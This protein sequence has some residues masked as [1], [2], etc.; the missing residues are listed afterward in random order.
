MS[1]QRPLSAA[2]L[3]WRI[4]WRDGRAGELHV[5]LLAVVLAV[6]AMTAVA[7]L[8]DRLQAALRRDAGA[9]LGGDLVVRSDQPLPLAIQALTSQFHLQTSQSLSF[10][11]MVRAPDELGGGTKLVT[12]KAVDTAYPLRGRLQLAVVPSDT[13]GVVWSGPPTPGSVWVEP[14]LLLDLG[15]QVGQPL[16]LG[17]V[18]LPIS[19]V[20]LQ[21]PDRGAGFTSFLPRVLVH[22][23][24][25]AATQLVQPA[26]RIDYRLAVVADA[27]TLAGYRAALATQLAASAVRGVSTETLD[28]G[29]PEMQQTLQRAEQFLN[30]VALL[31]TVL[32]AVAVALAARWYAVRHLD[33]CAVLRVL[34][35][36]QHTMARAYG[37]ALLCLALLASSFGVAVGYA[38][39]GLLLSWLAAWLPAQ[40]PGASA[41]PIG[42]G[43]A[44]GSILVLTFAWPPVL[45]LAQVPPLRVMR[46]ELGQP[47]A[48]SALVFC[49]GLAGLSALLLLSSRDWRLGLLTVC[50]FGLALLVFAGL[51][52]CVLWLVRYGLAQLAWPIWV[53]MVLRQ[54]SARPMAAVLQIST[55]A[56]GLLAL[57]LLGLLRIE[58]LDSWR[59]V[60][61]VDAPN[62]FVINI[63]PEQSQALQAVLHT[64]GVHQYDWYPMVRGRLLQV[65]G[66][67]VNGADYTQER[68]QRL[69]EREFNLSFSAERPAHNPLTAGRWQAG[70]EDQISVEQG[71]AAAL[72]LQ[73][74]DELVFDIAGRKRVATIASLRQVNWGSMRVNFFA[75]YPV[76]ELSDW[77]VTYITAFHVPANSRIDAEL[78]RLFPNVTVLDLSRT[79]AQV[80]Q[81]LEQVVQ[82][83]QALFV[84]T[85]CAGLLVLFM[86]L[87]AGRREREQEWAVLRVLG[88]QAVQLRRM[89]WLEL[90]GVGAIAGGLAP[91]VAE[92]MA[93]LLAQQVLALPWQFHGWVLFAGAGLGAALACAAGWWGLRGL[94]RT[95]VLATLRRFQA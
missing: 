88:A 68:A 55:L 37:L 93:A 12:L 6:A 84:F 47:K 15:L 32:S 76:A 89:Q 54:W 18:C 16:C 8:A 21:E 42:L 4:V 35:L 51:A 45:Q 49:L 36:S 75:I 40:L 83:V 81:V 70:A 31:A 44:V 20:V 13:D 33:D 22:E 57:L 95:P 82:A 34:G 69:V 66:H 25:L 78:V 92:I 77:P 19:H 65:N 58:L 43:L 94:L 86:T 73:L 56:L 64:Q 26:S 5:L 59:S 2:S 38:V 3:A 11:T 30:L 24:D 48:M 10:S 1:K 79:L 74:G 71:L 91:V 53:G 29:R 90:S 67:A 17:E 72:G 23:A 87:V 9:L 62:R 39:H 52:W 61:P 28:S 63:L 80:Q 46:R 60:T 41:W 14:G 27:D 7:F 85:L 50:G